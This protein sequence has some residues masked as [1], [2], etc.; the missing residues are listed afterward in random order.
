MTE[1]RRAAHRQRRDTL[2]A[3]VVARVVAF[4]VVCLGWVFF[5]SDS[6]STAGVVLRRLV[7]EWH[8]S[9]EVTATAV[10]LLLAV[11]VAQLL[12][13]GTTAPARKAF[14]SLGL[15]GQATGLAVGLLLVDAFGPTGVPPFI[16]YRF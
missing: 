7:T 3:R 14:L 13:A 2:A 16:Y 6:L 12:P 10:V 4:H 15:V 9:P 5:A 11:L 1:R 8:G